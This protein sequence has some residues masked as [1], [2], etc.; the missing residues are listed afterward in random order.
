MEEFAYSASPDTE[1]VIIP[2]SRPKPHIDA[3]A[4]GGLLGRTRDLMRWKR[5]N[6]KK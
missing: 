2:E 6:L 4:F 5:A 1:E 3:G